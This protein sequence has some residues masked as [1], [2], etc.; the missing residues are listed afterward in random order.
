VIDSY[1]VFDG[2]KTFTYS[3]TT[4]RTPYKYT[5]GHQV[6]AVT[7]LSAWN[8]SPDRVHNLNS[9]KAAFR[10]LTK[11]FHTVLAHVR[12]KARLLITRYTNRHIHIDVD[13]GWCSSN[14]SEGTGLCYNVVEWSTW[15]AQGR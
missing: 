5:C 2:M 9:T 4:I 6:F 10:R 14:V 15:P 1:P 11:T 8:G 7:G 12:H 3:I 13:W